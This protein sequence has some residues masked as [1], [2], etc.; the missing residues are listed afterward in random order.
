MGQRERFSFNINAELYES[1]FGELAVKFPGKKVFRNVGAQEGSRFQTDAVNLLE[2]ERKPAEWT[3]MPPHQ[4]D[5]Q[6]WR[7]I[8]M[9]G[10]IDGDPEHPAVEFE[11][12]QKEMGAQAQSY[13][14]DAAH[15][16]H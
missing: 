16:Q 12:D 4:L 3:E 9:L 13:L 1:R 2:R 5:Y 7:C 10:Y 14:K 8:A 6:E 11:V 15:P